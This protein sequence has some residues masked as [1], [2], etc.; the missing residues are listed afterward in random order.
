MIGRMTLKFEGPTPAILRKHKNLIFKA[1]YADAAD[2]WHR[3]IRPKHFRESA[4]RAYRYKQRRPKT[5]ETKRRKQK[6]A[7]PLV[8]T[9]RSKKQT[10]ARQ[11]SAT[12]KRATLR[13]RTGDI[14]RNPA[15]RIDTA[16]E[17]VR[18]SPADARL[19]GERFARFIERN[20]RAIREIR[21][22]RIA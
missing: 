16:A 14:G 9:G 18:I 5:V 13:M 4:R 21:Q 10:E 15:A 11:I 17:L 20:V 3:V 8:L 2:Y 19:I 22:K 6:H 7:L 1:A 12:S